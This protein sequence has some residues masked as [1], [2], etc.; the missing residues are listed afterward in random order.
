MHSAADELLAAELHVVAALNLLRGKARQE[1]AD[2]LNASLN[3]IG[4]T[5]EAVSYEAGRD[6]KGS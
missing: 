2:R 6:E 3:W 1:W 5:R 4:T